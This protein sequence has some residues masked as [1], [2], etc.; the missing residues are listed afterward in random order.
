MLSPK[1]MFDS[2]LVWR[3]TTAPSVEPI[4]V[5]EVKTHARI[6]T[7]EEDTYIGNLITAI[8]QIAES[9][10]GRALIQ[11]TITATMDWWPEVVKLPRPPLI[12]ITSIKTISE[13][14]TKT[15]Y[16][17]SAY[18]VRTDIEP[19]QI[20]IRDGSTPPINTDRYHGGFEI[21]Y[22]AGYGDEAADVPQA[23]KFGLLEWVADAY[24]NRIID[25]EPPEDAM[26]L[27][28]AYRINRI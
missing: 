5:A 13:L 16:D 9:W 17:S 19:G 12:S 21:V 14:D 27:L 26:P 22:L 25:R 4:T 11:Q 23:I 1:K 15:T 7:S 8:R 18:Y 2:N 28:M 3:V 20:I 24:E 6:E 10:L